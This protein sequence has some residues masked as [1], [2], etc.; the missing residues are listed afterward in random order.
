MRTKDVPPWL[1]NCLLKAIRRGHAC[2]G[3]HPFCR[4]NDDLTLQP[5]DH[6]CQI[7]EYVVNFWI[8]EITHF[9][10]PSGSVNPAW[11]L[12]VGLHQ[13]S[14]DATSYGGLG[15]LDQVVRAQLL[16]PSRLVALN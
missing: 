3:R 11:N 7:I 10:L 16:G 5:Q 4:N 8:G 2:G 12:P 9:N 15:H 6:F 13:E 14:G 1:P